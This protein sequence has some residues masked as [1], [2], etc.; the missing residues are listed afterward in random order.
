MMS[1]LVVSCSKPNR[2]NLYEVVSCGLITLTPLLGYTC[3]D[4]KTDNTYKSCGK[5]VCDSGIGISGLKVFM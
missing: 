3:A 4:V 5:W 1:M 2:F